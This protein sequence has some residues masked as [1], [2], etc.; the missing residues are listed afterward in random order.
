MIDF[1][2][3]LRQKVQAL[4]RIALDFLS[5]EE[6]RELF[7]SVTKRGRGKRGLGRDRNPRPNK[8]AERRRRSREAGLQIEIERELT[9]ADLRRLEQSFRDR[10]NGIA[11]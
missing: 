6:A 7:C 2:A 4:Y 1:E 9:E 11:G 3:E 5:E 10:L 8:E